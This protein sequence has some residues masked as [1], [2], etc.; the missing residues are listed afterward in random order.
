MQRVDVTIDGVPLQVYYTPGA[1]PGGRYLFTLN[2]GARLYEKTPPYRAFA[3]IAD[4]AGHVTVHR[5]FISHDQQVVVT[6][7]KPQPDGTYTFAV[8]RVRTQAW[9][10]ELRSLDPATGAEVVDPIY[11]PWGDEGLDGHETVVHRGD[12]RYFL[13]YRVRGEGEKKTYDMEVV[14]MSAKSGQRVGFWTSKGLFP[15]TTFGDYLHF[16]SL[17]P[18]SDDQ[19][20]A[21]ARSTSTLY[22]INLTTRRIDD[23]ISA[24]TWKVIGDPLN[25]FSRQHT[26]QFRANGNLLLFDNRDA[27]EASPHSRAVE[28]A[29]DWRNRTL[30]MVWQMPEE[31]TIPFRLGWG[32]A[33]AIGD[34]Q[35]LIGWGDFPRTK[36]YCKDRTDSQPVFTRMKRDGTKIFEVRAPCGWSTY[37]AYFSPD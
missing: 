7:F 2:D 9:A 30:R 12:R 15:D 23:Q 1:Q 14:S 26:A 22:L 29:V 16:N 5:R 21:S 33:V 8:N 19:V 37:R 24:S 10:Y 3:M 28:Y 31:G 18:V 17:D 20:L 36:G 34:D 27:S 13:F 4:S 32:S 25:G 6:D 35:V 11:Y